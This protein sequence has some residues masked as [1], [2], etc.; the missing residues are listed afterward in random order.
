MPAGTALAASVAPSATPAPPEAD[1][2]D[3]AYQI[4][5]DHHEFVPNSPEAKWLAPVASQLKRTAD[6]MYGQPFTFYV[7][8]STEPNAYVI[9]GPR[10]YVDRG[11]ID[12][13]GNREELAGVLCHEMSHAMHHD[14]VHDDKLQAKYDARLAGLMKRVR[15]FW[16]GKA[17]S[18]VSGLASFGEQL[19]WNHHSRAEETAADLSGSDLCARAG[20]NPWGLVWMFQKLQASDGGSGPVWLSDHPD[21][22]Q[23]IKDLKKHFKKNPAV[24]EV[25]SSDPSTGH[26]LKPTSKT[27]V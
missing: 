8:K 20:L 14:G 3:E 2:G 6:Q 25:W 23:R 26:P 27:K 5:A 13:A 12:L 4:M 1:L 22:K 11:L 24:F 19:I 7:H 10:V 16:H 21:I 18:K 15:G 17:P 9:Y